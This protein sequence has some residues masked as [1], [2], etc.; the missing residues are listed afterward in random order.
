MAKVFEAQA[1]YKEITKVATA[2]IIAGTLSVA[3]A[4]PSFPIADVDF[5]V[6]PKY[7]AVVECPKV[8]TTAKLSTETWVADA[9]LYWDATAEKVTT[10]STDNTFIGYA[11]EA[12]AATITDGW[13]DFTT[14][15]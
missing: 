7:A 13:I 5:S 10:V 11:M 1:D 12:A 3:T 9:P 6:Q 15:V 4:R 2:D 14:A 8:K